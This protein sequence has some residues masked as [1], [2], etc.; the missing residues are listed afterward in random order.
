MAIKDLKK[1]LD[2]ECPKEEIKYID[3]ENKKGATIII[4]LFFKTYF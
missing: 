2:T 4:N 3:E 1:W